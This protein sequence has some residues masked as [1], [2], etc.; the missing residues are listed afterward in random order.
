MQDKS[1]GNTRKPPPLVRK[2]PAPSDASDANPA[3]DEDLI[4]G[5]ARRSLATAGID[6]DSFVWQ[7]PCDTIRLRSGKSLEGGILAADPDGRLHIFRYNP[8][9][10]FQLATLD[11]QTACANVEPGNG[12]LRLQVSLPEQTPVQSC[13]CTL[14]NTGLARCRGNWLPCW[15]PRIIEAIGGDLAELHVVDAEIRKSLANAIGSRQE[16]GGGPMLLGIGPSGIRLVSTAFAVAFADMLRWNRSGNQIQCLSLANGQPTLIRI[17]EIDAADALARLEQVFPGK[18]KVDFDLAASFES[19]GCF[20]PVDAN[21]ADPVVME[22]Q[23]GAAVNLTDPSHTEYKRAYACA[24]RAVLVADNGECL[25]IRTPGDSGKSICE[26]IAPMNS[27]M[28]ASGG[29]SWMP[30][31]SADNERRVCRLEIQAGC[32]TC[33]GTAFPYPTATIT[34][35]ED[36]P[37]VYRATLG[38]AGSERNLL[39]PETLIYALWAEW[40]SRKTATGLAK[41]GIADLYSQFNAAKR[42]NF[43]L[44]L[45]GDIVMLNR[46]LDA[47]TKMDDLIQRIS[48][49][50]AVQFAENNDLRNATVSKILLLISSLPTIKQKFEVLA[51]MGPYHW[52][53][54]EVEWVSKAFG[55][56]VGQSSSLSERKRIVPQVRRQ[57]R[58]V[59]GDLLRSLAQI[60]AAARPIESILAKDELDKHWSSKVRKALP[61]AVQGTI[62]VAMMA[63]TGGAMGWQYV[64]GALATTTLGSVLGYFQKDREAAAQIQHA[65][66]T[67]FP[68]WRVFIKTLVVS[69]FESAEFVDGE[70]ERAMKRDRE[71]LNAV[72]A[73]K[74]AATLGKLQAELRRRIVNER[75]NR[76]AEVLSGSGIRY[77]NLLDD[78]DNAAET[79]IRESITEFNAGLITAGDQY[80]GSN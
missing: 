61:L 34:V 18:A 7:V 25:C 69:I 44:L 29:T 53:H 32:A 66:E 70:N 68:W 49:L 37:G 52:A 51:T 67:I 24:D 42:H 57:V 20:E 47:G 45:F 9:D 19:M 78:L 54:Q 60:E 3:S 11:L 40:D 43:L 6:P 75:K 14:D 36:S 39:G 33:D 28:A 4:G 23:D 10:G 31:L 38:H 71:M 22:I 79:G 56:A 65:A 41:A 35:R 50:G 26:R 15:Q 5:F 17:R 21:A 72:S 64:G 13:T 46:S 80:D 63:V 77:Q 2:T 8:R 30:L 16:P 58:A 62:G 55:N 76:F 59:Q 74:R 48:E 27:P 12:A 1:S 73:E